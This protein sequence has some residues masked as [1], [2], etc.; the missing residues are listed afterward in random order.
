MLVVL[1]ARASLLAQKHSQRQQESQQVP[2]G[3]LDPRM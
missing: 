1:D 2:K 3:F